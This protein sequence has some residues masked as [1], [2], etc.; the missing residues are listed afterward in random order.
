MYFDF[1]IL[2]WFDTP[3]SS[4]TAQLQKGEQEENGPKHTPRGDNKDG[5]PIPNLFALF[6][7]LRKFL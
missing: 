3:I 1:S 5:P 4:P 7:F 2:C 6:A